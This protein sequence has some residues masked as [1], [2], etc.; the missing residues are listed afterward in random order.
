MSALLVAFSACGV[1]GG[2]SSRPIDPDAVPPALNATTTTLDPS[3]EP[4]TTT[5]ATDQSSEPSTTVPVEPVALFYVAG[6]QV[7]AIPRLLLSPAAPP[8]VLAAL[9]EGLPTGDEAAGLRNAIPRGLM[10][11]VSVER[12]IATVDLPPTFS[13]DV[14][15]SDQRLAIA[16]IV[17]T[18]T[19]RAGIGQVIFTSDRAP[20]AVPRGRGDLTSPGGLVACDDYDNL[21]PVGYS[22]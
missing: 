4:T 15:G 12:G 20:L 1:P 14:Q 19:R 21:L 22:C 16:Q 9:A 3:L 7:V 6:N 10:A 8:Q 5:I 11:S 2:S 17:L 13:V 18:L